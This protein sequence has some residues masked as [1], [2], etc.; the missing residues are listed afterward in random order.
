MNLNILEKDLKRL[1]V[2]VGLTRA[3]MAERLGISK[4][5]YTYYENERSVMPIPVI[6]RV[7][8]L[9]GDFLPALEKKQAEIR[10]RIERELYPIFCDIND[11]RK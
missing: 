5:V 1:R 11:N 2:S 8:Q 6:W 10:K 4:K 7:N 3:K 9:F